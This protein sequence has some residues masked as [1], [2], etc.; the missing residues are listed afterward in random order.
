[1]AALIVTAVAGTGASTGHLSERVTERTSTTWVGNPQVGARSE[2]CHARKGLRFY[3]RRYG[4]HAARMGAVRGEDRPPVIRG[5]PLYLANVWKRKSFA[6][7]MRVER[8]LER[9]R[10]LLADPD[11][12][13][14]YVFGAY[15]WQAKRVAAC[16]SG[17]TDGDLS[18]HVVRA[19]NGQYLGMFQM[20]DYARSRYGHGYTPLAQARAAYAYFV[21]SGRDWSPWSCKP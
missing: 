7:R 4:E 18:L 10:R 12:A 3:V 16:E 8:Y 11:Y 21:A 20:G 13:I 9:Q 15:A 14:E 5:C 6:M 17:D 1:M 19:T 2:K